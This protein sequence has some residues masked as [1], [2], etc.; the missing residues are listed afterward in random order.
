MSKK[1]TE[2]HVIRYYHNG[3]H[4]GNIKLSVDVDS[5]GMNA[6]EHSKVIK[7][8]IIKMVSSRN[9]EHITNFGTV[10]ILTPHPLTNEQIK[11]WTAISGKDGA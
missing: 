9:Y 2:T 5:W 3:V 11:E 10:S 7:E 8:E 4:A 6:D 1:Y